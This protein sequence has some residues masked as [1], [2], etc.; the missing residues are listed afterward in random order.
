MQISSAEYSLNRIYDEIS[1]SVGRIKSRTEENARDDN[2]RSWG[3]M[4]VK[5]SPEING[6][7]VSYLSPGSAFTLQKIVSQPDFIKSKENR[8]SK[9]EVEKDSTE[10]ELTK[11]IQEIEKQSFLDEIQAHLPQYSARQIS[12]IYENAGVFSANDNGLS[13]WNTAQNARYASETYNFVFNINNEPKITIDLMHPNN[14]SFD[15]RI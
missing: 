9:Q 8:T 3:S 12:L 4:D 14:R 1:S 5:A 13:G 7:T 10:K 2:S 15:F 11:D 6:L